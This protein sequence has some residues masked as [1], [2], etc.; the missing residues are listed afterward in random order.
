MKL[1]IYRLNNYV[2]F[3]NASIKAEE[4]MNLF[5]ALHYLAITNNYPLMQ[6]GSVPHPVVCLELI[7]KLPALASGLLASKTLARIPAMSPR[8]NFTTNRLAD[9]SLTL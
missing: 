8:R 9:I 2:I 1:L 6:C 4:F 5:Q 3:K 7:E